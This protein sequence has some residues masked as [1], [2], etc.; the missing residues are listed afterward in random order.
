MGCTGETHRCPGTKRSRLE[1]PAP[2]LLAMGE[3]VKAEIDKFWQKHSEQREDKALQKQLD[4]RLLTLWPGWKLDKIKQTAD[5]VQMEMLRERCKE[6]HLGKLSKARHQS[7]KGST[8]IK[9]KLKSQSLG[10]RK[11]M[12]EDT[13]KIQN[14]FLKFWQMV[15]VWHSF[16]RLMGHA[17]DQQD[18]YLEF[19]DVVQREIE[20]L[21]AVAKV[22]PLGALQQRWKDEMQERLQKLNAS[23]SYRH[24][25]S[26]RLTAWMGARWGTPS[27]FTEL[28]REQEQIRWQMTVQGFD[29][30]VWRAAFAS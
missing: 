17:V 6:L 19:C 5:K 22:R 13:R 25:Y 18:C 30:A 23:E 24:S 14:R 4:Q 16:E 29:K 12:G 26:R 11:L 20:L 9:F 1:F 21:E 7:P 3:L 8:L 15:K 27:K 10:V 28:T 2:E